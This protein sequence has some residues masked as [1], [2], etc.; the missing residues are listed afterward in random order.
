[1]KHIYNSTVGLILT[2]MY[3]VLCTYSVLQGRMY[4]AAVPMTCIF[5]LVRRLYQRR[6]IYILFLM[7]VIAV[8]GAALVQQTG[9][10]VFQR[11]ETFLK[12][13]ENNLFFLIYYGFIAFAG[14]VSR[15]LNHNGAVICLSVLLVS[16][17]SGGLLLTVRGVY[18]IVFIIGGAVLLIYDKVPESEKANINKHEMAL[19]IIITAVSIIA[20]PVNA[21][22]SVYTSGSFDDTL[23]G[24]LLPIHT[25]EMSDELG[26]TNIAEMTYTLCSDNEEKG[27]VKYEYFE[28]SK[29]HIFRC[30][31]NVGKLSEGHYV[32]NM[33]DNTMQ[34]HKS[35]NR[36][37]ESP[38]TDDMFEN[39]ALYEVLKSYIPEYSIGTV[40]GSAEKQSLPGIIT[41]Y[42]IKEDNGT[43]KIKLI[44]FMGKSYK[45]II[46]E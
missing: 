17:V 28:E 26:N 2:V 22:Y 44:Y 32:L 20:V 11:S 12:L 16:V 31:G 40:S 4:P 42:N 38:L 45:Y 1:M 35:I 9:N 21:I 39:P 7:T 8:I 13:C 37:D 15:M 29:M 14:T 24:H 27:S 43:G 18:E 10:D 5:L 34:F 19:V 33:S 23:T 6:D 41:V 30:R 3:L 36:D 25:V 46:A